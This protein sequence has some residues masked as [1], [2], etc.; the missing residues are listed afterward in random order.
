MFKKTSRA[1]AEICYCQLC[2]KLSLESFIES[3]R[4]FP[5]CTHTPS[6]YNLWV[7]YPC[8]CHVAVDT[9][10]SL[11]CGTLN[12][13]DVNVVRLNG[14][15]VVN[16]YNYNSSVIENTHT[17]SLLLSGNKALKTH[18]AIANYWENAI[19]LAF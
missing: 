7:C 14:S 16:T 12:I 19:T 17:F 1:H 6:F 9:A 8:V 5:R 15:I 11:P 3:L 18:I 10:A 4:L 2:L 13:K